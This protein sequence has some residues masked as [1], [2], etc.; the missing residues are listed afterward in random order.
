MGA[1]GFDP[2][3][4]PAAKINHPGDGQTRPVGVPITFAG[5]AL[6]PQDGT[7][8]GPSLVWTSDKEGM[9]GTGET[10]DK[11]L[12]VVGTHIITLTATDSDKNVGSDSITQILE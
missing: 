11:A 10:F 9:F 5:Q 8:T 1:G 7:L 3:Q 4:D 12:N 2:A 6:D